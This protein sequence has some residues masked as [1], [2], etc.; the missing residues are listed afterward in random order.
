MTGCPLVMEIL[1][2][3]RIRK[4]ELDGTISE[5]ARK[6]FTRLTGR[7]EIAETISAHGQPAYTTQGLC[8]D[9]G[10]VPI[11]CFS[12]AVMR[13][14]GPPKRDATNVSRAT[15]SR[16]SEPIRPLRTERS[17]QLDYVV[18][19]NAETPSR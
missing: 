17:G 10:R 14:P 16:L 3:H 12:F 7:R 15:N 5:E 6:L 9:W 13:R 1:I 4:K 19:G 2:T 18:Y 11:V 8:H